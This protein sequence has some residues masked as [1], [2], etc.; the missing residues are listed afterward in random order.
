MLD[1]VISKQEKQENGKM[2]TTKRKNCKNV[3]KEENKYYTS[4]RS[5]KETG[6]K[7]CS[8]EGS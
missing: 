8:V 3:R 1:I 2:L 4:T 7:M 6:P 5:T